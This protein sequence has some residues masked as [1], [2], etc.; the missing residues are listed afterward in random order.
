[1][2]NSFHQPLETGWAAQQSH[3]AGDT[4]KLTHARHREG[5][6]GPGPGVEDH[7]PKASKWGQ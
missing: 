1:M 4:L 2:D 5:S 7:L 3:G 6:V